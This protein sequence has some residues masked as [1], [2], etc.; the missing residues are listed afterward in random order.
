Q[1]CGARA[2][3]NLGADG[4]LSRSVRGCDWDVSE[5]LRWVGRTMRAA[6]EKMLGRV[7]LQTNGG[8]AF[9]L[10]GAIEG[11]MRPDVQAPTGTVAI[12]HRS[13]IAPAG[14]KD[15]LRSRKAA[16]RLRFSSPNT[17]PT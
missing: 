14:S 6:T 9:I 13:A 2:D 12:I 10:T 16:K 7:A 3:R 5:V 15:G 4:G 1:H 11:T 17:S 8:T